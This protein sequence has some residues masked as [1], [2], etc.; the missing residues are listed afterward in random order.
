M[1]GSQDKEKELY[2]IARI[3]FEEEND[4]GTK[5]DLVE[6]VESEQLLPVEVLEAQNSTDPNEIVAINVTAGLTLKRKDGMVK[7]R[8]E[9]LSAYSFFVK[10]EKLHIGS[11]VKLDMAEVNLKW[12]SLTTS[13]RELYEKLAE[14]D[15]ISLGHNYRKSRKRR[16]LNPRKE[17]I[18][19]K[20]DKSSDD[21]RGKVLKDV[22]SAVEGDM[23]DKDEPNSLSNMLIELKR[24]DDE[25]NKKAANKFELSKEVLTLQ[26]ETDN[27]VKEQ[28]D[29]DSSIK[30]YEMKCKVLSKDHITKPYP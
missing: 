25:I 3:Q 8:T 24:L 6:S 4:I 1:P 12:R 26:F 20:T 14:N 18:Q 9:P 5:S 11:K 19:T 27:K 10:E 22:H 30:Y 28:S 17:E 23:I 7:Q 2:Q 16:N 29:L 13:Q 15:K 21:I